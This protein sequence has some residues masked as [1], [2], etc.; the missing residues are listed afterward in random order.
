MTK[1]E[2]KSFVVGYNNTGPN[3]DLAKLGADGWELVSM[4]PKTFVMNI[5]EMTMKPA[6]AR[7]VLSAQENAVMA[8]VELIYIFKR[9]IS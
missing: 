7:Q 2:Y 3:I 5:P 6:L 8:N 4:A 9:P 1:W